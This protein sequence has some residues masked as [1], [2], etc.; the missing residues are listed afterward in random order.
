MI[1]L[2]F[3]NIDDKGDRLSWIYALT[4]IIISYLIGV[5]GIKVYDLCETNDNQL[6]EKGG[7]KSTPIC[8]L[9]FTSL[10]LIFLVPVILIGRKNF[11]NGFISVLLDCLYPEYSSLDRRI[12]M[13]GMFS[14]VVVILFGFLSIVLTTASVF[15]SYET[16]KACNSSLILSEEDNDNFESWEEII[17]SF[18]FIMILIIIFLVLKVIDKIVNK[19]SSFGSRVSRK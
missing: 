2:P 14:A 11:D 10:F 6:E 16:R 13:F 12:K 9:A 18:R 5:A 1:A 4:Y 19:G 8:A 15:T 7:G 3:K 17:I